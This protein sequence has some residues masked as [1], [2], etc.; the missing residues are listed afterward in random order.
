[1]KTRK[2]GELTVSAEGLG[3]MSMSEYYGPAN[4]GAG[5]KTIKRALALGVN[6]FDTADIYGHGANE[7]LLAEA[8]RDIP[9]QSVII[10]TKCGIVRDK[11]A[12]E[13]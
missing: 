4:H 9:R 2:L 13:L 3:C 12:N 11:N 6:F 5:L 8:F 10:A 1:M 7:A